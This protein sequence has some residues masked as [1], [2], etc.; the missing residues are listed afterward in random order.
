MTWRWIFCGGTTRGKACKSHVCRPDWS[1]EHRGENGVQSELGL[2]YLTRD[3]T[4][5]SIGN[6]AGI[7]FETS[8][9]VYK[10]TDSGGRS[11]DWARGTHSDP[12]G[13]AYWA[14]KV[15]AWE[16]IFYFYFFI[17][18]EPWLISTQNYHSLLAFLMSTCL[19]Q[20]S[21]FSHLQGMIGHE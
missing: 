16:Q 4:D 1:I 20:I 11:S 19:E 3:R 9:G 8:V 15:P 17:K 7:G 2:D 12:I 6:G 21:L 14:Y 5:W 18:S 10:V 13:L